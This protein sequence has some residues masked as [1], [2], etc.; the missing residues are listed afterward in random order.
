MT[1]KLTSSAK[2]STL[3]GSKSRYLIA[4]V[5]GFQPAALFFIAIAL[6]SD[7]S[8]NLLTYGVAPLTLLIWLASTLLIVY[9]RIPLTYTKK[10]LDL[11]T[12]T[13]EPIAL[14]VIPF[15]ALGTFLV[16]IFDAV[17]DRRRRPRAAHTRPE[18]G[19]SARD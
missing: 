6:L 13:G 9:T 5:L 15:F 18:S 16:D 7:L 3:R 19:P 11:L 17:I 12:N 8:E 4:A 14:V 2:R 1:E 10:M